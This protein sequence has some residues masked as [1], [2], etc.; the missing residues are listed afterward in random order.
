MPPCVI[1]L[2]DILEEKEFVFLIKL[3]VPLFCMFRVV[4]FSLANFV[5]RLSV[6]DIICR[7]SLVTFGLKP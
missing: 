3:F 6:V 7:L 1:A 5:L 4:G 2:I